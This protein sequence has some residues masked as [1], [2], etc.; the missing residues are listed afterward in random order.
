MAASR[1]QASTHARSAGVIVV[2]A[3]G[4][5]SQ[6]ERSAARAVRSAQDQPLELGERAGD[7]VRGATSGTSA[8]RVAGGRRALGR[9]AGLMGDDHGQQ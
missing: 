8:A 4:S 2:P 6:R 1:C 9:D 5:G 3:T 7:R